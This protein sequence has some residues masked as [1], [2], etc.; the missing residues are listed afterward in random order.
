[1]SQAPRW[2]VAGGTGVAPMLSMLRQMA[3]F[4]DAREARLFFGVNTQDELFALDAIE[5]LKKTLPHL[6]A[7]LC[8]WK[9]ALDWT[10]FRERQLA[11]SPPR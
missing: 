8:V 7:T 6:A 2:F 3:E 11:H 10:G 1:M 4:G 5:G 9:P